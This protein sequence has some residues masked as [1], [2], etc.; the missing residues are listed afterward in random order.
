[1]AKRARN[2][3]L[4]ILQAAVFL[5]IAI[6]SV[7][8]LPKFFGSGLTLYAFDVGQADSYLFHFPDGTNVLVDAG[9]RKSGPSLAS[10]LRRLGVEKIDIAVATHPHEDHIGGMA[11]IIKEFPIE[12]F[13]DSGYNHGSEVQRS[14]LESIR[15]KRIRF[16]RPKAG[17]RE[18]IGDALIEVIAPAKAIRGTNSDANNN[19]IVLRVT[20]KDVSFLMTGDM[21][22]AE[23]RSVGKF[24]RA[25]VLKIAHHGSANGT[26]ERFLKEVS[27]DIAILSYGRGNSYGHPHRKVTDL[28]RK[29]GVRAYSTADGE[30]RLETDGR[31][32]T[33]EQR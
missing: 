20:Y 8:E 1:M 33:A 27:P 7:I 6:L 30:V 25:T 5:I 22:E 10:R 17:H 11:E 28:L 24:P 31:T 23:R 9:T 4:T 14:M 19:S 32:I 12:R 13:W 29:Y 15:D 26:D 2:K 21:E 18:P 3:R 16:E